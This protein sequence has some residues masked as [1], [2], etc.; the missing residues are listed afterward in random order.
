MKK[1][2]LGI[3]GKIV[4]AAALFAA[5]AGCEQPTDDH[6]PPPP[7]TR[8]ENVRVFPA[9][10]QL[11]VLWD[12][13]EDSGGYAVYCDPGE[14]LDK[15]GAK[16]TTTET[17]VSISGLTNSTTYY[18]CVEAIGTGGISDPVSGTPVSA[19]AKPDVPTVNLTA[20]DG[21]IVVR[22]AQAATGGAPDVYIVRIG[23]TD[24]MEAAEEL[25]TD[26]PLYRCA[27]LTNGK[28]YY[29]WVKAVNGIG[30]SAFTEAK[31]AAPSPTVF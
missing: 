27:G 1:G 25:T 10:G 16:N 9:D 14:T 29:V 11:I 6:A 26:V 12:A 13:V 15:N 17:A 22:M 2:K 24:N 18:V 20:L 23:E 5:F 21:A 8:P 28:T 7:S 31:S 19:S 4:L 3:F 30:E